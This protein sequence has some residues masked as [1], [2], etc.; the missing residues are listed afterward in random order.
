[1]PQT[2]TLKLGGSMV[3]PTQD[4][5]FDF[6]FARE[7]KNTLSEFTQLGDK[8]FIT[9][10][11]GSLMR[12]YRDLA[13]AN[14]ITD[15]MQIHWIGT[16]VNVLNAE[17]VRVSM[18]ELA[19]AGVYKYDDYYNEEKINI[20]NGVKVGGGGKP[21]H[22]GDVDTIM[23]ARKLGSKTIIS[24]KNIDAVY[25]AD[26]KTD[27]NAKP[28]ERI[29]WKDYLN[30]I[31]NPTEHKPG[32]NFPIDPIASQMAIES[33][34]RFIVIGGKDMEN[35]KKVLRGESFKGTIVE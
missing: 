25:T 34:L 26:P 19:D 10:G 31:G 17:V 1:M 11:G 14:G 27:P 21:G 18:G 30:I 15:A 8:F 9:V 20:V 2:Y 29:T 16:T 28:V 3:S 32:A 5:L 22:S 6:P 23:A 4:C 33:G 7:L 24:L 35:F 13:I 12:Q